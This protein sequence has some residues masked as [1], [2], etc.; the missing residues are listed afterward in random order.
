MNPGEERQLI[1]HKGRTASFQYS[2]RVRCDRH[3]YGNKCN[4]Q[5]RPRDDYFGHYQCDQ[6]GNQQCIEGWIGQDCKKG[7]CIVWVG[8]NR[9]RRQKRA[10]YYTLL[11]DLPKAS[12][13]LHLKH[14]TSQYEQGR[15]K[16]HQF[17]NISTT[18][19]S[20]NKAAFLYYFNL[21][22]SK[23]EVVT[24]RAILKKSRVVFLLSLINA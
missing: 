23:R 22:S 1:Q 18:S 15:K 14:I 2:V 8:K 3:Y 16:N 6:F 20:D 5:C 13:I 4:K 12:T 17:S 10:F 7:V 9:D 11:K 24:S 19:Q 21:K